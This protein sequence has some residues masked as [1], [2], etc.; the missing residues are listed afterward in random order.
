[1]PHIRGALS[2]CVVASVDLRESFDALPDWLEFLSQGEDPVPAILAVNKI[3][4]RKPIDAET[5]ALVNLH[6]GRFVSC[7]FV[8]ALVGDNI[9]G[10][11]RDLADLAD[12]GHATVD[13]KIA[14][15]KEF[16]LAEPRQEICC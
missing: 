7:F 6:R 3:D 15:R 4:L 14:S 16:Q 8:S 9:E 10:L 11:F 5:T 13:E 1:V 12:R 2:A